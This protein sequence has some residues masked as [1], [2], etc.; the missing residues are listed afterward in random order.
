MHECGTAFDVTEELESEALALRR[1]GNQTGHV[2]NRENR[3]TDFH[4]T[5]VRHERG[6]GIVRNF[7]TRCA[8]R[9]DQT[10]LPRRR[11]SDQAD[12]GNR[13]EFEKCAEFL[14]RFAEE[15]EARC[16]ALR[17]RQ[18]GISEPTFAAAG[19][20]EGGTRRY[21][22]GQH[23]AGLVRDHRARRHMQCDVLAA[24]AVLVATLSGLAGGRLAMR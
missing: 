13:L 24:R 10:R 17:R 3:V 11:E 9:G 8:D 18:R 7:R 22:I 14:T 1:T 21:E 16:P 23:F 6:E 20:H 15:R 19:E 4:H 5:E 12:V 2:G